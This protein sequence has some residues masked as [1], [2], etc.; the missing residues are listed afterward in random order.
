MYVYAHIY[1][2]IYIYIYIYIHV[3]ASHVGAERECVCV[4]M[5]LHVTERDWYTYIY[6]FEY[7]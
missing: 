6:I 2:H 1:V 7:L 3:C 5:C 4:Y